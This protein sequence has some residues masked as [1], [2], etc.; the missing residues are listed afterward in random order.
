LLL[1]MIVSLMQ[2]LDS[3]GRSRHCGDAGRK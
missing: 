1:M 2:D 3:R